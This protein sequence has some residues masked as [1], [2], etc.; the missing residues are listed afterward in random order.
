MSDK[1]YLDGLQKFYSDKLKSHLKSRFSTCS[2]CSGTKR[3]IDE[4]GRLI[5]TCGGDPGD[6]QCGVQVVI[7]LAEYEYYPKIVLQTI[8]LNSSLNVSQYKD[9]FT[10]EEINDYETRK[11]ISK[12]MFEKIKQTFL[13]QNKVKEQYSLIQKIHRQRIMNKKEQCLLMEKIQ[14]TDEL[15]DKSVLIQEYLGYHE[16]IKQDYEM[17]DGMCG[18]IMNFVKS[19]DGET[20]EVNEVY[21]ARPKKSPVK[22]LGQVLEKNLIPE[23]QGVVKKPKNDMVLN[24]IV[25]YRDPGDGSRKEQLRKF[26]EQMNLLFKD[27]TTL[28]IYIIE[29]EGARE[30]YAMLP[31]LIQQPNSSMAKFNLGMLKNIGFHIASKAM[32]GKP[33]AYYILS[34]VDLL[35]SA[36]LVKDYLTYPEHPIHLGNKGTRYNLDGSDASFL[37]GVLSVNQKDFVKAN[38]YPNNFWGWGGED[39]SLNRRFKETNIPIEKPQEPVIDLENLTL[40][41]KLMK[42]REDKTKEM[43]KR[44]KLV[45]DK[46][47]WKENGLSSL[48]GKYKIVKKIKTK[49]ATHIKVFLNYD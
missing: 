22:Q 4:P 40:E 17:L 45:E 9:I 11:S 16:R 6:K 18:D 24:L 48:E 1:E 47:T 10:T 29:Q 41:Q 19:V 39:N 32:K 27:Q 15:S 38:G 33:K 23:L 28:K 30:D 44:E 14:T 13:K 34:D 21:K 49:Y 25:A 31:E 43:R 7:K 8:Q 26:K 35:P 42:L 3:F 2:G 36:N 20:Q 37:G 5:Y 46:S 12:E